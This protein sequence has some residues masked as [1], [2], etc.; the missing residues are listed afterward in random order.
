MLVSLLIG[1]VGGFV[2]TQAARHSYKAFFLSGAQHSTR[3]RFYFLAFRIAIAFCSMALLITTGIAAP[4]ALCA[5]FLLGYIVSS[6]W[7]VVGKW[8]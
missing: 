1:T 7:A 3:I 6:I 5:G 2:Y 8:I 4:V